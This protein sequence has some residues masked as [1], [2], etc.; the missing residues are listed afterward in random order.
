[1]GRTAQGAHDL[2]LRDAA[3]EWERMF[4]V[5]K[6]FGAEVKSTCKWMRPEHALA[7]GLVIQRQQRV[8]KKADENDEDEPVLEAGKLVWNKQ[9]QVPRTAHFKCRSGAK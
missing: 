6:E 5:I 1:M 4:G 9:S 8:E 2:R 7:S 3:V